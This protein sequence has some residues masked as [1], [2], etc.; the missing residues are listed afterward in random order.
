MSLIALGMN[1]MLAG[2]LAAALMMGF[3]LN[4][5]LK[6]LRDSHDGFAKA[7]AELDVAA[8]RAEQGLADLRAA[9]DEATDAL[10]DRIEK[11]RA[12]TAKLDRQLQG[13]PAAAPTHSDRAERMDRSERM[14]RAERM[15][16]AERGAPIPFRREVVEVDEEDV[17]RVTHRLGALLSAAREPR[18]RPEPE[19]FA[20][21]DI[22]PT[23][24]RPRFEDD[25]F[26]GPTDRVAAGGA[27]R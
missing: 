9:T 8:A 16:R 13:A 15:A 21:P 19:R 17:A 26:D 18:I 20:R 2:L 12:L 23:R 27:R 3:R 7:V 10:A 4:G 5:R 22:A 11:A 25:L 24:Q 6:H 1:L 14:D